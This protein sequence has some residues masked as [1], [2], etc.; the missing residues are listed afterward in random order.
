MKYCPRCGAQLD[1]AANFCPKCGARQ[2][3]A[4]VAAP[5]QREEVK[6]NQEPVST[7]NIPSS[8][9]NQTSPSGESD[10]DEYQR[11]IKEDPKFAAIMKATTIANL[12]SLSNILFI[13]VAIVFLATPFLILTGI[14]ASGEGSMYAETYLLRSLPT[15]VNRVEGQALVIWS[16]TI[17]KAFS[18]NS[19]LDA[20]LKSF[21]IISEILIPVLSGVMILAA[22][23]NALP[24]GYRFRTYKTDNGKTLYNAYKKEQKWLMGV[25]VSLMF[26]AI[27][28]IQYIGWND[29]EYKDGTYYYGVMMADQTNFIATIIVAVIISAMILAANIVVK[30]I[31]MK[32]LKPL[33]EENN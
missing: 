21:T 3:D 23:L 22:L 13:I 2:P 33:F 17:G 32:K 25:M 7:S 4:T 27:S 10:R 1:D 9:V 28:V 15:S 6:V 11:M 31:T 20:S 8:N 26:A 19:S 14:D 24:K 30:I 12:V 18:P 29:L 5:I 16:D